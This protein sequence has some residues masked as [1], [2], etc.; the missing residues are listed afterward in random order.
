MLSMSLTTR[1]LL[2]EYS[3][4]KYVMVAFLIEN[5]VQDCLFSQG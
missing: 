4:L 5:N 1:Q 3:L 2:T